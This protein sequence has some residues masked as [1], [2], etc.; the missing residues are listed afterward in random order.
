MAKKKKPR[1]KRRVMGILGKAG[2]VMMAIPPLAGSGINAVQRAVDVDGLTLMG[3]FQTGFAIF[4]N[5]MAEGYGFK[6]PY[7]LIQAKHDSGV[8]IQVNTAAINIPKG[9]WIQ[10]TL[11]GALMLAQDRVVAFVLKRPVKVPGTNIVLTGN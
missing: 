10:T 5:S 3:R 4:I 6:Q 11:I 7:G 9:V 1:A 8:T 2:V